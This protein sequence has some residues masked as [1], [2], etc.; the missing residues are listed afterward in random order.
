MFNRPPLGDRNG[1]PRFVP[2]D[3]Y[4]ESFG[5]QWNAYRRVQLDSATGK[6]LSRDRLFRGTSWPERLD[7]ERIL[8]VGAGAGRFTEVLLDAGAEVW[9]VDASSAVDAARAN[10]GDQ[11]RLHLAQ[12][13]LFDL[14][15]DPAS[16]DRVLCFGV[17]Q[18]T[19]DPRR[20]FQTMVEQARPGGA[21]G[22]DVYRRAP[23]IDR[24]SAK[25]L[26]RPLT[27]RLPRRTLRRLVEWYVPR[28]LPVDT[29]LARVPKVGRFLT[30][31]LPCWNYT[32]LLDL[33]RDQLRAWA[34][35]DTFD[36]LSPRYDAPQDIE[37]VREW[38]AAAGL[39]DAVVRHGGNGIE[40]SGRR[41]RV[42]A[43]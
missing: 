32:G 41:P 22:A 25:T 4:A 7:G 33:D 3:G 6:P 17:L 1:I 27:T 18:H 40:I 36:A 24:W 14:P 5:E 26:W 38:V 37:T 30:A 21:V 42:P 39:V 9:A 12:A 16:F 31:A 23:Y 34:I 13:D 35:L 10:L 19:P 20:A 29:R 43:T 28:W 2:D 11:P 8:E 15:F